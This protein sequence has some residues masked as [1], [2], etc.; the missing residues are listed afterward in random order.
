MTPEF[1]VQP[2]SW[3]E[4]RLSQLKL[5]IQKEML[6]LIKIVVQQL[7][8]AKGKL[9]GKEQRISVVAIGIADLVPSQRFY[10]QVLGWSLG[11]ADVH[12]QTLSRKS[13]LLK[14]AH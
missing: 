11:S 6:P 3:T 9:K 2:T 1:P 10:W 12:T 5:L 8:Q 4:V 13:I 7:S 14:N